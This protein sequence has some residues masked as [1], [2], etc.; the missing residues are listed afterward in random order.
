MKRKIAAAL[1]FT[2]LFQM[3][4]AQLADSLTKKIDSVFAEYDKTNSPG[5]A[6]AV[7]KDGNIIYKRGYGMSNMEYNIAISPS[8][9]FHVASVSKQFAAAAII[10]LSMEGKLSLND[11]IRKYIPQVPDFGH[12]ITFNHLLHH[13]SGLRD[14]WTLQVLAGWRGEDLI[15][16]KDILEMLARQKALNFIPGADYTYCNTGYTLLGVAVKNISGV[17]LRDYAD[18]VF[19]KPLGMTSTHFHSDHSEIVPNRTSAYQKNEKGI[20]KISIPVFDTYGA[21]S[22]F[23]TVEDLAKWDENFYTRK[24]GGDAFVNTMQ[25]TGVLN[26]N[27]AQTYA[28]GL[29]VYN[30][31]GHKTV[32]HSGADAGYRSNFLRFPDQHFSVVI[33]ANLANINTR[34]LSNKVADVFLKNNSLKIPFTVVEIDSTV[35]KGLAGD[36]LDM[37]TKAIFKINYKNKTLQVGNMALKPSGNAFFTDTISASTYS[38]SGDASKARFVLSEIG[39]IKR[40]YEKVKTITLNEAQ[41]QEYKGEFYSAELDTKYL[42]SIKDS[43][44]N[45]KI[46]RRDEWKLSPFVKD[47]FTGNVTILFSRDNANKITGF[48]LTAGRVRNLYFEKIRT[49]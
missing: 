46:P 35:V 1:F 41:L 22:L 9:I 36:Y 31:K 26:D 20:W 24:I 19:F 49:K 33:L 44:L 23:T 25:A 39:T 32:E 45:V 7:L 11:D 4:H 21:T 2:F 10:R 12:T 14:Q 27:T 3:G 16:E 40:T 6:L 30:Y 43:A 42:L 29:I 8:S 17:S 47:M 34:T 28:S 5:C 48:F 37:N 13:T 38:F 18:A 15:T